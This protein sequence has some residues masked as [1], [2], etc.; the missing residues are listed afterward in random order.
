MIWLVEAGAGA[1]PE[2]P[3]PSELPAPP[4]RSPPIAAA[5]RTIR[6]NVVRAPETLTCCPTT[7]RTAISNPSTARGTR[8]PGSAAT[9]AA[10]AGS[11]PSIASTAS[12]SASR[13][14]SRR[15]RATA[16]ARSRTSLSRRVANTHRSAGRNATLAVPCGRTS[17]RR[18]VVPSTSSTPGSVRA[19]RNSSSD[20]VCSGARYARRRLITPA[21]PRATGRFSRSR[22]GDCAYT[23]S[24]VSL[25]CRTLPN[26]A[27]NAMSASPRSVVSTR[28]RAVCARCARASASGPAPSSVVSIRLRCRSVYPSRVASPVT[29]S[30]STTPSPMSRIA[31]PTV[32]AR[33][34]HSGDPGAASGRHRRQAR[35]PPRW[36]AAALT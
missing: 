4:E 26:P 28:I 27:A 17:P 32:S 16:G 13:S 1:G 5:A 20:D 7:A 34:S 15:H 35:N 9:T 2:G 22:L 10:S 36:A 29:P 8:T 24:I 6:P 30:R 3:T 14:N 11:A 33:A 12:G 25:N 21:S 19:P 18:Y 23:S 31:R